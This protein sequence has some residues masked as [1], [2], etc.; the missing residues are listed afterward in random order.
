METFKSIIFIILNIALPLLYLEDTRMP[1]DGW[2]KLSDSP[3]LNSED[4]YCL[5]A[6]NKIW[7]ISQSCK[8]SLFRNLFFEFDFLD[9]PITKF[10]WGHRIMNNGG[11]TVSYDLATSKWSEVQQFNKLVDDNGIGELVFTYKNKICALLFENFGQIKFHQLAVFDET[12][13]QFT[14]WN[15]YEVS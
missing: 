15:E 6:N 13:N 12:E 8:L 10:N 11:Y 4:H 3:A 2:D 9:H 1:Y 14:M 7:L 5:F